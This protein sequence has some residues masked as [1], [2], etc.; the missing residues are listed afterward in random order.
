MFGV[1]YL[2]RM[3]KLVGDQKQ[4]NKGNLNIDKKK[5]D[6]IEKLFYGQTTKES[7]YNQVKQNNR[8]DLSDKDKA[9]QKYF[10]KLNKNP[11]MIPK[12]SLLMIDD[13]CVKFVNETIS[14]D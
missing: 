8:D 3:Q 1:G 13:G 2:E 7:F 11:T 9:T 4:I 12:P 5:Q 14:K 10:N 6:N